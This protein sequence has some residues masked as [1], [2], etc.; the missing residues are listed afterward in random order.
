MKQMDCSQC[1]RRDFL[2]LVSAAGIAAG[3][4]AL[5]SFAAEKIIPNLKVMAVIDQTK[6][7]KKAICIKK[8]P[9]RAIVKT[10]EKKNP[11]YQV[12]TKKCVGCGTCV[13]SCPSKAIALV[14]RKPASSG[15][16]IK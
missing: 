7:N 10:G 12:I 14:D 13:K 4:A 9:F 8:C 15:T 3:L 11:L 16:A 2:K 5:P 1:D 6:C